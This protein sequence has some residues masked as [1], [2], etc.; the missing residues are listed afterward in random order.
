MSWLVYSVKADADNVIAAVELKQ[1]RPTPR[2]DCPLCS[3]AVTAADAA[4]ILSAKLLCA[5]ADPPDPACPWYCSATTVRR[6]HP[7]G[8][9]WAVGVRAV[10]PWE[11][12]QVT[13]PSGTV[14]TLSA[15]GAVALD[16]TWIPP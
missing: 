5:C 15:A 2:C 13:L 4:V 9:L 11:G 16:D 10:E 3:P 1:L 8:L 12:Q 14:V 6:D 7:G